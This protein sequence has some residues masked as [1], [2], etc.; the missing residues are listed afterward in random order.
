MKK[1]LFSLLATVSLVNYSVGQ[2]NNP[3][4]QLGSD[5]VSVARAIMIDY[6]NGKLKNL[7]EAT[8]NSYYKN[9]LPN[10]SQAKLEDVNAIVKSL[11]SAT[12]SSIIDKSKY[13]EEGKKFLE[14]TLASYSITSLVDDVNKSKLPEIEKEN[15]LSVLAINYNLIKPEAGNRLSGKAAKTKG[16]CVDF[17]TYN[18]ETFIPGETS[19]GLNT[20]VFGG[21]GFILGS[22]ICGLPCGIVGGAIGLVIGGYLDNNGHTTHVSTSSGGSGHGWNPQP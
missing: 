12:N 7:D 5:V 16:P 15:I 18:N 1:I 11:G 3:Y 8:L 17:E 14:K 21:L 4:N 9:L 19:D 22:S 20:F 6:S 10:Y 13:S 2:S